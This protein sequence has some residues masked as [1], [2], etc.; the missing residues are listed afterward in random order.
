MTVEASSHVN[1]LKK[2]GRG[3]LFVGKAAY[4][5]SLGVVLAGAVMVAVSE[6][7]KAYLSYNYGPAYTLSANTGETIEAI[8]S[9]YLEAPAPILEKISL[10]PNILDYVHAI[11][12]IAKIVINKDK[13]Q[14]SSFTKNTGFNSEQANTNA[15]LRDKKDVGILE[16]LNEYSVMVKNSAEKS[17]FDRINEVTLL[18]SARD[19]RN[20]N[21]AESDIRRPIFVDSPISNLGKEKIKSTSAMEHGD[22]CHLMIEPKQV[23]VVSAE[24]NNAQN[25]Y[26][27]KG[28]FS[29]KAIENLIIQHE[30]AH[31]G[32]FFKTMDN[33]HAIAEGIA[34]YS[35]T[36]L[37][38][39]PQET[40][41]LS[42]YIKSLNLKDHNWYSNF[43]ERYADTYAWIMAARQGW[44]DTTKPNA[45]EY[46]QSTK[47]NFQQGLRTW[48]N[49][50][51]NSGENEI[52]EA[53]YTTPALSILGEFE[54]SQLATLN[55]E[56]TKKLAENISIYSTLS[57]MV[58]HAKDE[59]KLPTALLRLKEML[60]PTSTVDGT[61]IFHTNTKLEKFSD[62]VSNTSGISKAPTPPNVINSSGK[63][64][65]P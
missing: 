33:T 5:T 42:S 62:L 50:R 46:P 21:I 26:H 6:G 54:P 41:E 30:L 20:I 38:S 23:T 43:E 17:V 4:L 53:H 13:N 36:A 25:S 12:H 28:K 48:I 49:W 15:L 59:S 10:A 22:V 64:H 63:L 39:S 57:D 51:K 34:Y 1:Y 27:A 60:D 19:L 56:Q 18:K 11:S 58:Y 61:P 31:C 16:T 52:R 32:E 45:S 7:E 40:K 2:V 55:A 3:A 14:A 65:F 29:E 24:M 47:M 35:S 44:L 8:Q 9:S 37:K